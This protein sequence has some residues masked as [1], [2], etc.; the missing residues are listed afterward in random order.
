MSPLA[1]GAILVIVVVVIYL[2]WRH[3][4][5][6][7]PPVPP[8][9]PC[10]T[11]VAG[12][13]PCPNFPSQGQGN[14][15]DYSKGSC[16]GADP[17][18]ARAIANHDFGSGSGAAT[19]C[20]AWCILNRND[21][22]NGWYWNP[23]KMCFDPMPTAAAVPGGDSSDPAQRRSCASWAGDTSGYDAVM[24]KTKFCA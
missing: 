2:A 15:V 13:N 1:W 9:P 12:P 3:M 17:L 23:D 21:P 8:S 20:G 14:T 16:A 19:D 11:P 5:P 4:H 22:A 7:S 6:S 18:L 24:A 10:A